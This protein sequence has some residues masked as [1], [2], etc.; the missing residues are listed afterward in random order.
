M[1]KHKIIKANEKIAEKV[2]DTFEKVEDVVTGSYFKI[3][4]SFVAHYLAKEGETVMDAKNRLKKE[5]E[6]RKGF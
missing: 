2:V 6:K 4:D 5:Q 1:T 3:E